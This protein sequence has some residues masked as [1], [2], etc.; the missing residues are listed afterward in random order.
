[1]PAQANA[2]P[3]AG[4]GS[5]Q[6]AAAQIKP[7]GAVSAISRSSSH[8]MQNGGYRAAGRSQRL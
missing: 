7:F 5:Q 2:R 6:A 8:T 4:L 3:S 1:M